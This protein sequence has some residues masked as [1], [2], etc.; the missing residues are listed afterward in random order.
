M[1]SNTHGTGREGEKKKGIFMEIADLSNELGDFHDPK[2]LWNFCYIK[3]CSL[4]G[5]KKGGEKENTKTLLK[6]LVNHHFKTTV[7]KG[8]ENVLHTL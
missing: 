8:E 2:C 6:Q 4:R 5:K 1:P 3:I 7:I